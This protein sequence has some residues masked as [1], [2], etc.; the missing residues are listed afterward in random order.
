M[1]R[2]SNRIQRSLRYGLMLLKE[3]RDEAENQRDHWRQIVE[4][5]AER[6]RVWWPSTRKWVAFVRHFKQALIH[7]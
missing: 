2:W 1:I 6:P 3:V 5:L 4:K 7:F